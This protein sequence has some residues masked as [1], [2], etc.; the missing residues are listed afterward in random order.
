[1]N[2]D[3]YI[4]WLIEQVMATAELLGGEL[5]PVAAGL[6]AEDLSHYPHDLVRK[7]LRRVRAEHTGK[8]TLKAI[9][10]RIDEAV[11]RPSPNEAWAT[12]SQAI[13]ESK[14]VV[15]TDEIQQAWGAAQPLAQ[16]GDMIGARMAFLSAYERLVRDARD[17]RRLPV[18]T[19][20]EGWDAAGRAAAVEKAARLGY[21]APEQAQA[22]LP[23]PEPVFNP[24]ALLAGRVEVASS[25]SPAVRSRLRQLRE[26]LARSSVAHEAKRIEQRAREER[27]LL[28]RKGDIAQRVA[29]YVAQRA[30]E[31]AA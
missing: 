17:E 31:G 19:I 18:V 7:A 10:D 21:V 4:D 23:A 26:D 25:A 15:W 24:V 20:S 9:I 27:E 30:P 29:D 6:M 13:D 2:R 22:Y 3:N 8:L 14:T 28:R 16:A 12:A 5:K 1:M 11:G